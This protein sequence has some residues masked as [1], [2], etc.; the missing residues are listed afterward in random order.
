MT[1]RNLIAFEITNNSRY[2]E[3]EIHN[4]SCQ[5]SFECFE[6]FNPLGEYYDIFSCVTQSLQQNPCNKAN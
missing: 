6:C 3:A 2:L 5:I 1:N 4:V